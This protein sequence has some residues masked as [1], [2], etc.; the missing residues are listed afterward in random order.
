M[1]NSGKPDFQIL[2]SPI[3][4]PYWSNTNQKTAWRTYKNESVWDLMITGTFEHER[5]LIQHQ[6]TW[7]P[8]PNFSFYLFIYYPT[9]AFP[10]SLWNPSASSCHLEFNFPTLVPK[11]QSLIGSKTIACH[12]HNKQRPVGFVCLFLLF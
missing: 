3:E 10:M 1:L 4:N 2:A 11:G 8:N 5:I 7:S 12:R 9:N 6:S